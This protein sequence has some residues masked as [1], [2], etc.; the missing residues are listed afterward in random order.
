MLMY[1]QIF[2]VLPKAQA[3]QRDPY[4]DNVNSH[5]NMKAKNTITASRKVSFFT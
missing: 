2:A 3:N 4:M 5:L 1:L